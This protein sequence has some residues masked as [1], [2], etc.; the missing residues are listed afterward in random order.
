MFRAV[1]VFL[2]SLTVSLVWAAG[3]PAWADAAPT[4]LKAI[5][6]GGPPPAILPLADVRPGMVGQALT[7]FSGTKPEPFKI[8]VVAVMR[9][10]LPK[11]DVDLDP[12]RGPARR[13]LR[14]RRWNE[15]QPGLH[16]RQADGRRRLRVEL[17]QGA[18]R[19]RHADRIDARRAQ[20]PAPRERGGARAQRRR[21]RRRLR[22]RGRVGARR[23]EFAANS[24]AGGGGDRPSALARGLGLPHA[25]AE[26]RRRRAAPDPRVGAA[27]G[28]GLHAAHVRRARPRSCGPPAW[29]RC[30]PAAAASAGLPR[31]ARPRRARARRSASSWCAA[32]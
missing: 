14:H 17:R 2:A 19:R 26:H 8:R 6:P 21:R 3:A 10:F 25:G 29:C 13:V 1:F 23:A 28:R 27:V 20:P 15:R 32:T 24:V 7:V 5:V 16:R 30:R 4:R 18:A 11:Q 12:R 31:R 22:G 9:N